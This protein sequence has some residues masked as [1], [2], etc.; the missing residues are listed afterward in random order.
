[1]MKRSTAP[2]PKGGG[3]SFGGVLEFVVVSMEKEGEEGEDGELERL[4]MW[5][6]LW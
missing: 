1:M 2:N 6:L 3:G 5:W 4:G